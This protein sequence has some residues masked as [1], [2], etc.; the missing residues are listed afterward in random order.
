M[1]RSEELLSKSLPWIASLF[2]GVLILAVLGSLLFLNIFK[3]RIYPGIVINNIAVGG[4]TKNEVAQLIKKKTKSPPSYQLSLKVDQLKIAS[5]SAQLGLHHDFD[6]TINQAYK[7]GRTGSPLKKIPALLK[8]AFSPHKLTTSLS[9]EPQLVKQMVADLKA[10]VD[11]KGAHPSANL[12]SSNNPYTL[13]IN[14]GQPG[15]ELMLK[16][17]TDLVLAT[18]NSN[19]QPNNKIDPI[20][21]LS[22]QVASTS[23]VLTKQEQIAAREKAKNMI[24]KRLILKTKAVR[25]ELNDQKMISLLAFPEGFAEKQ[26]QSLLESWTNVVNRPAQNAVFE[27]DPETLIVNK[28]QPDR[29]GLELNKEKT[30]QLIKKHLAQLPDEEDG[31]DGKNLILDLPVSTTKAEKTLAETNNLNIRE[32]IGLGE[33]EYDHSIPNRIHN[34]K[35]TTQK[36]SNTIIPPGKEFSFNKTLG[37]VSSRTGYKPAYVIKNGRTELGGGGGVCQVSTTTFRAALDAGLKITRRLP[38]SYRVSYYELNSKPGVDATVYAGPT[39]FRFVNDTNHHILLHGEADSEKLYMKI[40]LYG[41]SDSRITEIV[42]HKV[43]GYVSPPPPE[44]YPDPSLPTGVTK[45]IDWAVAGVKAK[46]THVIKDASGEVVS[47]KTYKSNYQ[48]WSAK[49]LVGSN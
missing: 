35:I 19:N 16:Q 28:F 21:T 26:L 17:T 36:I 5:D 34:V 11:L 41:T 44:Y 46:F 18:A 30:S 14:P 42:D 32:R 38:H 24:G 40:E 31:K 12:G 3:A 1:I 9:F 45:Q 48:P 39:D 47:Q 25:L 43:W 33:S 4:L 8:I 2:S 37:E 13:K 27:Y 22:A 7:I 15:R 49:Y 20:A 6:S 23:A 29:P 10:R